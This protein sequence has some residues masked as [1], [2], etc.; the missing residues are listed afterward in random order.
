[1]RVIKRII[2]FTVITALCT[3]G[4]YDLNL[5]ADEIITSDLIQVT[6]FQIRKNNTEEV[7]VAFRTVC[8]TPQI[9]SVIAEVSG[10]EYR[11]KKV[12]TSYTI[13]IHS[14]YNSAVT[15]LDPTM[16]SQESYGKTVEYFD[17]ATCEYTKGY[18]ATSEGVITDW[19]GEDS[20]NLH[21]VRTM[22]HCDNSIATRYLVRAFVVAENDS[23][24][25]IIV[26]GNKVKA[27]TI[28]EIADYYYRNS[29]ASNYQG[30]CFLY[31][32]I[33]N[34]ASDTYNVNSYYRN[35]T[36]DYGWNDNLFT[37]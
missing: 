16:K 13:D 6:G 24:D 22:T 30:H 2:T 4:S 35:A 5:R 9:G 3:L 27:V 33:L 17:G 15:V 1:M 8:T 36:L 23:G 21:Y 32:R 11:I 31:D 28:A 14:E 10:D 18:I 34:V 25:E 37:P 20:E 19:A 26:Y 12:G 7:G 29:M